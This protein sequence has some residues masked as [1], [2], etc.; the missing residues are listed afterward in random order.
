[1]VSDVF[2][3]HICVDLINTNDCNYAIQSIR[4]RYVVRN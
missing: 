1:M 3:F 2:I 4:T